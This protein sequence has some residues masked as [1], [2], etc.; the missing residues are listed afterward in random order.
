MEFFSASQRGNKKEYPTFHT[1]LI[2]RIGPVKKNLSALL[3]Q[4]AGGEKVIDSYGDVRSIFTSFLG[5]IL[6]REGSNQIS[7]SFLSDLIWS[8]LL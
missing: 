7:F 4:L 5:T 2:N 3:A 1:N 8:C 6:S